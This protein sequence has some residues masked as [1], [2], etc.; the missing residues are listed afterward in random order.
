MWT[1]FGG[2]ITSNNLNSTP[3]IF[4]NGLNVP[5]DYETNTPASLVTTSQGVPGYGSPYPGTIVTTPRPRP[6]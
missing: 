4:L 6:S 5:L 2:I 1:T 3:N